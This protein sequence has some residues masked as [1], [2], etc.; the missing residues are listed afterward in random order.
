MRA[1]RGRILTRTEQHR[2]SVAV[3]R[4]F[5]AALALQDL[6][7]EAPL[8]VVARRYGTSRG[9]LQSL[10]GSASTFAGMVTVF[11]EKLGWTNMSL[12]L[13]QFQSRL[14]FGVERELCDLVRVSLLN[15]A[16]ARMLYSAGYH[17]IASLATAPA[18]EIE[19]ILHNAAPFVSGLK[20]GRETDT[21]VRERSEARVIW[22]AGRRGLTEAA[23]AKL[24]ITEAKQLL[25]ADVEE[26]GI[27]W[28]PPKVKE[29]D[30][31][32]SNRNVSGM[33]LHN[34]SSTSVESGAAEFHVPPTGSGQEVRN[35]SG[36]VVD[37]LR[38]QAAVCGNNTLSVKTLSDNRRFEDGTRGSSGHPKR[39]DSTRIKDQVV[40][41][42]SSTGSQSTRTRQQ[43][44]SKVP[45][46]GSLLLRE[47]PK[48]YAGVVCVTKMDVNVDDPVVEELYTNRT[49]PSV[50]ETRHQVSRPEFDQENS[51]RKKE[52]FPTPSGKAFRVATSQENKSDDL[53]R[54][55]KK[56][57]SPGVEVSE[58]PLAEVSEEK[59]QKKA[60][61]DE[62]VMA[63]SLSFQEDSES[64]LA[65]IEADSKLLNEDA[66]NISVELYS[67]PFEVEEPP[68][69]EASSKAAQN[70]DVSTSDAGYSLSDSCLIGCDVNQEGGGDRPS[71]VSFPDLNKGL[72]SKIA[73]NCPDDFINST[74]VCARREG[75]FVSQG[76]TEG[77]YGTHPRS[78]CTGEFRTNRNFDF[79]SSFA[80]PL[81]KSPTCA[82]TEDVCSTNV[83]DSFVLHLSS[84]EGCTESDLSRSASAVEEVMDRVETVAEDSNNRKELPTKC[85]EDVACIQTEGQFTNIKNPKN[86]SL[87]D[88]TSKRSPLKEI[89]FNGQRIPVEKEIEMQH[90]N[91]VHCTPSKSENTLQADFRPRMLA[92]P[93]SSRK[94]HSTRRSSLSPS[95]DEGL[96]IIDV[97]GH[98]QVF[99]MFLK[100]WHD[101]ARFSL[102]VAC[103]RFLRDVPRIGRRFSNAPTSE[104]TSRGLKVEGE[105]RMVVGV[106]VS[107]GGKDAYYVSLQERDHSV[108][109]QADDSQSEA[110]V[111]ANLTLLRRLEA[112]R[113]VIQSLAERGRFMVCFD[114]KEHFK[115]IKKRLG[116]IMIIVQYIYIAQIPWNVQM[117]MSRSYDETACRCTTPTS[118]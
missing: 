56:R 64:L 67:E 28:K 115:V 37:A 70:N 12:L 86:T 82:T 50:S 97:T 90:S 10:Q 40:R 79:G 80:S 69:L 58:P 108:T 25:Q 34:P 57:R 76:D 23:A 55:R 47:E 41:I 116:I 6:V 94:R 112:V 77:E 3:H 45:S 109:S 62:V 7:H 51:V 74:P 33:V 48:T 96:V 88:S 53:L 98:E 22:V 54:S 92:T 61:P 110:A 103:E 21:E 93:L 32:P 2:Q 60:K 91:V 46:L 20:R 113:S 99:E 65:I 18:S 100:E 29:N 87:A 117:R 1:V 39:T 52:S 104:G 27:Q 19:N 36:F 35:E 43:T 9:M 111:D 75:A 4:K 83:V 89:S 81:L 15:A 95:Q 24:I 31:D 84:S 8:H 44:P 68:V 114:V 71:Q 85:K 42:T 38:V 105:D 5:Y 11:C 26:L 73:S 14:S 106:A 78:L 49:V 16:R 102:A 63:E 13:S 107:W 72:S 17:T 101:Q 59:L 66:Q 118:M 30:G